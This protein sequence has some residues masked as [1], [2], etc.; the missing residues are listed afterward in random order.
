[1]NNLIVFDLD[2]V[3][4]SEDAYWDAAGLTLHELCY[5]PSYWNLN[6]SA[7]S[8][9]G[10]YHPVVTAQESRSI[11]RALFPEEEILAL[12]ARAINSNWDT[13]YATV[14]LHLIHLLLAVPDLAA[15]LPLQPWDATWLARFR[16]QGEQKEYWHASEHLFHWSTSDEQHGAHGPNRFALFTQSFQVPIFRDVPG[17][18]LINRFDKYASE[19][20]GYVV[21]RRFFSLQS[22]LVILSG[23][24]S[25]VV[26]WG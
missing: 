10:H 8:A 18:E 14:C 4:T 11:S 6:A 22:F 1:M 7:S 15:L 25:R 20:L 21:R 5:S 16:K 12:K 17:L 19:L 2:G 26:S 24:I 3:I 13:C 9:D 23:Y